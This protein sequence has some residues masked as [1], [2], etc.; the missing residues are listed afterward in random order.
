MSNLDKRYQISD[1]RYGYHL[2]W[3]SS[4]S[5]MIFVNPGS[6]WRQSDPCFEDICDKVHCSVILIITSHSILYCIEAHCQHQSKGPLAEWHKTIRRCLPSLQWFHS[7][8]PSPPL[9]GRDCQPIFTFMEVMIMMVIR[10]LRMMMMMV[11]RISMMTLLNCLMTSSSKLVESNWF[12][13]VIASALY[14]DS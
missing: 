5:A 13:S 6:S 14:C 3:G 1:I 9:R 8:P 12:A 4:D 10:T 11:I 7:T 2:S